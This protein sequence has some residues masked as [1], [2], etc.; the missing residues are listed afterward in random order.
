[1]QKITISIPEELVEFADHRAREL[2]TSRSQVIVMALSSAKSGQEERL[3]AAGYRFYAAESSEFAAASNRATA[4]AWTD[5]WTSSEDEG[6][7]DDGQAR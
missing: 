7:D 3:A 2:Q 6:Q 4:E 1:M 5:T